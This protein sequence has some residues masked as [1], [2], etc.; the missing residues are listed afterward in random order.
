MS[1]ERVEHDYSSGKTETAVLIVRPGNKYGSSAAGTKI[2]VDEKELRNSSTMAACMTETEQEMLLDLKRSAVVAAATKVS[3][4]KMA[5]DAMLD[6]LLRN[7]RP[8]KSE[9]HIA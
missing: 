7:P 2:I 9:E 3:K 8:M 6:D 1:V 5:V 4:V